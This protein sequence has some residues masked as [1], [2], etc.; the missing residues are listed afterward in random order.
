MQ[1]FNI[2][3]MLKIPFYWDDMI[4]GKYFCQSLNY[5]LQPHLKDIYGLH[6]IKIGNLSTEINTT[7]CPIKYQI[8]VVSTAIKDS[9]LQILAKPIFLP[10][11]SK[12]IDACLSIHNLTWSKDPYRILCEIDRVLVN[13]GW[14]IISEFN[15]FSI[16]GLSKIIPSLKN[17]LPYGGKMLSKLLILDWLNMLNYEIISHT[18]FHIIPWQRNSKTIINSIFSIIGCMNLI[19]AR[20]RTFSLISETQKKIFNKKYYHQVIN[21]NTKP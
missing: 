18:C 12:S 4:W 16:L 7:N 17:Q 13:N 5:H 10:F 3:Q 2:N 14:V 1:I 8:S 6:M 9:C 11:K 20:K 19:I 21:A 15:S